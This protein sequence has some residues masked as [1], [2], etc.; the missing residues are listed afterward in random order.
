MLKEELQEELKREAEGLSPAQLQKLVQFARKVKESPRGTPGHT[1]RRFIGSIPSEDL[2][3]MMEAIDEGCGQVDEIHELISP[4]ENIIREAVTNLLVP[5]QTTRVIKH[6][7]FMQLDEASK[8][9]AKVLKTEEFVPKSVLNELYVSAQVLRNEAPYFRSE[10]AT[11]L[12]MANQLEMTLA[13]ILRG[14]S[15]EDRIPNVPRVI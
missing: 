6:E 7:A 15:H 10:T 1:L 14:E 2:K 3:L 13:L 5:L 11:L 4:I 9:L 12:S 8:Q